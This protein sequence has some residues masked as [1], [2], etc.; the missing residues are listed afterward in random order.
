MTS[1][2]FIELLFVLEAIALTVLVIGIL[3]SCT[4]R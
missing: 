1:S 4:A 2:L 3:W